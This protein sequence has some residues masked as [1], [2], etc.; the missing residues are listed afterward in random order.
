MKIL[1]L[2]A[3]LVGCSTAVPV[4]QK[5]PEVPAI[6]MEPAPNL[7]KL[8]SGKTQLSDIL[9]NTTENSGSYYQLREKYYAWQ[10]WYAKQRKIFNEVNGE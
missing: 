6:L 10:E 4:K 1:I 2:C 3:F 9:E 5:F 7:K 8:E